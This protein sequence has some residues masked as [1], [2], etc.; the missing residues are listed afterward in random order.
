M[1]STV[2]LAWAIEH[3]RQLYLGEFGVY[4]KADVDSR[5]RWTRF[6]A[7]AALERKLGFAYWEFCSGFG[8][9]DPN[10]DTWIEPMKEAGVGAK[11]G[12]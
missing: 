7:H 6:V 9:C 2:L 5:A 11:A 10:S 3:R 4:N 1:T 12:K 8:A